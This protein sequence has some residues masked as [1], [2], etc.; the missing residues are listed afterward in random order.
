MQEC[1]HSVFV[2][3]LLLVGRVDH[4]PQSFRSV[5]RDGC[6]W[7]SLLNTMIFSGK[8]AWVGCRNNALPAFFQDL[9]LPSPSSSTGPLGE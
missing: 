2:L 8:H 1:F 3:L 9:R 6:C 7:T 4:I 5:V